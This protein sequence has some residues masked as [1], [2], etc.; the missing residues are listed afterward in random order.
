[1]NVYKAVALKL[2]STVFFTCMG[3]C[4]RLLGQIYP[5]GEVVFFRGAF[6]I[7][8]VIVIYAL[9]NEL[10][11]TFR[12]VRPSGHFGRGAISSGAMYLNFTSLAFLP[13]VDATAISFMTPLIIVGL[14][15]VLL[16]E[17]VR[18][19]RW[20]AVGVGFGGVL[21][22]LVPHLDVSHYTEQA[23]TNAGT[24]GVL[25]G[26]LGA[27][28]NAATV[29]QTRRMT[30]T[31]TTSAIV[32]YFSLF[33]ALG[34]LVTLPVLG[35]KTPDLQGFLLLAAMGMLGGFAHILLTESYRYAPASVIAPLDYTAMI[36]AL[37]MGYFLFDEL[38]GWLVLLGA[39][40]VVGANLFVIW[41]ERQ[42]ARQGKSG[43]R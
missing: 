43:A 28:F 7:V 39:S 41:R 1:M 33:C 27:F 31:E 10:Y 38:P 42:I 30:E 6:A 37:I 23:L 19:Y 12:M 22:M 40:I 34:G 29:I 35:W 16:K 32:F 2:A 21:V 25:C 3:A 17:N 14:A 11:A 4:I 15:V 8:P 24:V 9:R 18:P 26:L 36:W 20:A 13:L 5:I